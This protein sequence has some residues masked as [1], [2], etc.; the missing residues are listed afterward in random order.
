MDDYI[1]FAVRVPD[2]FLFD[3]V[4]FAF[5]GKSEISLVVSTLCPSGWRVWTQRKLPFYRES[6]TSNCKGSAERLAMNMISTGK[7]ERGA[8]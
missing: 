7:R 8:A 6:L 3:F 4:Y 5:G 2:L 1:G